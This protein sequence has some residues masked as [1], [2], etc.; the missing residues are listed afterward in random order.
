MNPGMNQTASRITPAAA[1]PTS[2]LVGPV[3]D[4]LFLGNVFW[5]LILLVPQSP[6]YD[7]HDAV[8]FWQ[9]YFITTPHRWITLLFV[10]LD[11][12]RLRDR[13]M[14]LLIAGSSIIL[15]CGLVRLGTGDITCLL[16]VDYVWNA[17]HFAAQ[18]HGV[19]R[20][21]RRMQGERPSRTTTL[22]KWTL[23]GFLSY[24]ILRIAGGTWVW[25]ALEAGLRSADWAVL[26]IPVALLVREIGMQRGRLA[27]SL[28][29]LVSVSLLYVGLLGAVHFH[30]PRLV[31]TLATASALFHALEY[32]TLVGWTIHK[33]H[34]QPCEKQRLLADLA[35]QWAMAIA[36]FA[37]LLG[38]AGWLMEHQLLEVWLFANVVMAFL[39][40]AFDGL[41]WRS[42]RTKPVATTSILRTGEA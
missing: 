13:R 26:A 15:A 35:P 33:Y 8:H 14:A 24:V 20:I 37:I 38:S 23:R 5:P 9:L 4:A 6:S 42:A 19:Y 25:P 1:A 40:Y 30:Q 10:L 28:V 7:G 17:W 27:G 3:V 34:N 12:E 21:Y 36:V 22:E 11:G 2:W 39:H 31:L 32:L 18:H 16:A 29:Y 41:I